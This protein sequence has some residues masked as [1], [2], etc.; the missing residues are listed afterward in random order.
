MFRTQT[1]CSLEVSRV[2]NTS[3]RSVGWMA[4]QVSDCY[5]H[6]CLLCRHHYQRH[7]RHFHTSRGCAASSSEYRNGRNLP[8]LRLQ[9]NLHSGRVRWLRPDTIPYDVW[10]KSIHGAL[11][12]NTY[13]FFFW[14]MRKGQT[15]W[16][17]LTSSGSE[18][19]NRKGFVRVR[20]HWSFSL[21]LQNGQNCL[22][23][24]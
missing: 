23:F 21:F 15:H 5:L 17:I 16:R 4:S 2:L 7:Q 22:L 24:L 10:W 11:K 18:R 8:H 1:K 12:Y 13:W 9:T 14:G 6:Q 20:K 3:L 19:R